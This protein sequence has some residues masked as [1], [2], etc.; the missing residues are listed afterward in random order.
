M[1]ARHAT[2]EHLSKTLVLTPPPGLHQSCQSK[3][4]NSCDIYCAA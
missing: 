2:F 4:H 1:H 3:L